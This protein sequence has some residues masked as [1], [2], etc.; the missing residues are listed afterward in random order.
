VRLSGRG[1]ALANWEGGAKRLEG[2]GLNGKSRAND[3]DD[4][5]RP[6]ELVSTISIESD[7]PGP[8]AFA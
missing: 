1:S 7:S 6:R 2:A 8:L 4:S 3:V 5:A